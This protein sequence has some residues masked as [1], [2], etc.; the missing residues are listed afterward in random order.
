MAIGGPSLIRRYGEP[1]RIPRVNPGRP[2]VADTFLWRDALGSPL[3]AVSTGTLTGTEMQDTNAAVD[4]P[5]HAAWTFTTGGFFAAFWVNLNVVQTQPSVMM[6]H[7]PSNAAA[8]W[9]IYQQASAV[10]FRVIGSSPLVGPAIAAKAWT[11]VVCWLDTDGSMN[12][13]VNNGSVTSS[14]ASYAT[15]T[16]PGSVALCIG[17]FVS[18]ISGAA[19][20]YRS[21][22]I[23]VGAPSSD[24]RTSLYNSGTPKAWADLTGGEQAAMEGWWDLSDGSTF[25]DA[26]GNGHNGSASGNVGSVPNITS[27]TT[28]GDSDRIY[29]VQE[30]GIARQLTQRSA[31][32][33]PTY[34][35]DE[36]GGFP[37][38]RFHGNGFYPASGLCTCMDD[39]YLAYPLGAKTFWGTFRQR[40]LISTP[41]EYMLFCI[42]SAGG[43]GSEIW[44]DIALTG[45]P[46]RFVFGCDASAGGPL[47]GVNITVNTDWRVWRVAW[48]ETTYFVNIDNVEME[49]DLES[50]GP[51][52]VNHGCYGGSGS[53]SPNQHTSF[54]GDVDHFADIA[55]E[56]SHVSD[57]TDLRVRNWLNRYVS[58]FEGSAV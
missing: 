48:N 36:G 22:C 14:A 24:L 3:K 54:A 45:Y 37:V 51:F 46:A 47:P 13:Q 39:Q 38:I 9:D 1:V 32:N 26:T 42:E 7:L 43:L 12:I 53:R 19:G 18:H 30:I 23:G 34:V 29:Q 56:G 11:L 15:W 44:C 5:D 57:A 50:N 40:T 20:Y 25:T 10:R 17:G 52:V 6:S 33:R 31:N 21:A 8:G 49:I 35:A 2:Y 4:I 16:D 58:A 55:C 28:C 41:Q 27:T